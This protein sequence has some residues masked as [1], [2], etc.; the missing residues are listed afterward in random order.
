MGI[1]ELRLN[2]QYKKARQR[3]ESLSKAMIL[4]QL[5]AVGT[6][7]AWW[8]NVYRHRHGDDAIEE[9]QYNLAVMAGLIDG[10]ADQHYNTAR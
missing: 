4:N 5:D 6:D 8:V 2:R 9:L 7:M 1:K 3:S 10:L